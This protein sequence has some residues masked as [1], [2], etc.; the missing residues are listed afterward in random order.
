V[1]VFSIVD[2]VRYG[3][4]RRHLIP[5]GALKFLMMFIYYAPGLLLNQFAMSIYAN[6]VVN[7]VSQIVGIPLQ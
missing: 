3:S 7:A 6:G 4:L 1:R 5:L 2:L